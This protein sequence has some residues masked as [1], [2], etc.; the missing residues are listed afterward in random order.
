MYLLDG[1]N[2]PV[3]D[4]ESKIFLRFDDS[5]V[6]NFHNSTSL[7]LSFSRSPT[8][9]IIANLT[10]KHTGFYK[11]FR[12][13]NASILAQTLLQCRSSSHCANL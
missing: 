9:E 8:V 1:V 3:K 7:F 6:R 5:I 13:P 2:G 4:Q 11:N 12:S 10:Q